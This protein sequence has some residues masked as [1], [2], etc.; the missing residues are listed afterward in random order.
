VLQADG[1]T[2]K[3]PSSAETKS[4]LPASASD[5]QRRLWLCRC[6]P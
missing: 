4:W 6:S 1:Y 2:N 5:R 3:S